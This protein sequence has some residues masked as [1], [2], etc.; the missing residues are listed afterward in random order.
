MSLYHQYT[1][2][3]VVMNAAWSVIYQN[4]EQHGTIL[5]E[6]QPHVLVAQ[7]D[8]ICYVYSFSPVQGSVN[9]TRL[10]L[11]IT[12]DA[13][14]A[15]ALV[16]AEDV[17]AAMNA[18]PDDAMAQD[19]ELAQAHLST[20]K[21]LMSPTSTAAAAKKAHELEQAAAPLYG[22]PVV[23]L[24]KVWLFFIFL[25]GIFSAT[26]LLAL[27]WWNMGYKRK[28]LSTIGTVA[29]TWTTCIVL[30]T[31][32]LS[33]FSASLDTTSQPLIALI[34]VLSVSVGIILWQ[35][36]Q[37][38]P[39][40]QASVAQYGKPSGWA[41]RNVLLAVGAIALGT[42]IG[43]FWPRVLY[44]AITTGSAVLTPLSSRTTHQDEFIRVDYP[45]HWMTTTVYDSMCDAAVTCLI[46]IIEPAGGG[47]F[48]VMRNPNAFGFLVTLDS[49]AATVTQEL[50]KR[51]E[52]FREENR[53]KFEIDGRPALR[54]TFSYTLNSMWGY[55]PIDQ[56]M[57]GELLYIQD[58]S[59]LIYIGLDVPVGLGGTADAIIDS[60]HFVQ[61]VDE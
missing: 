48:V 5:A 53:V 30:I 31:I 18:L 46:G 52:N 9:K 21:Q 34:A 26:L 17:V 15:T 45:S 6:R 3:D 55:Q 23:T 8:A 27:N 61:P 41:M 19:I 11:A 32:V 24:A 10:D 35:V 56:A 7:T 4:A 47:T 49:L 20:L 42:I 43:I 37:Q 33:R 59:D 39:L 40:Y 1:V 51:P 58:G 29:I 57:T 50:T 28:A 38:R 44:T 13:V 60:V 36:R 54:L 12:R 25:G 16:D 14:A 22:V 2:L